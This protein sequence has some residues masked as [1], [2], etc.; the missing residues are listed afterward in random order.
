MPRSRALALVPL[1]LL[2]AC[3]AAPPE[4]QGP[5]LGE[6]AGAL[7]ADKQRLEEATAAGNEAVRAAGDCDVARPLIAEARLKFDQVEPQ[8]QTGAAR[9]SLERLRR[10]VAQVADL[11]P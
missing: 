10:Q 9:A 5:A 3:R 11:C 6:Q 4:P 2:L 8:L 1:A 7:A